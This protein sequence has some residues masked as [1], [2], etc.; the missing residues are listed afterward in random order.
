M[1]KRILEKEKVIIELIIVNYAPTIYN[2]D[3]HKPCT[4]KEEKNVNMV[5]TF[6]V[7][8]YAT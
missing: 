3:N 1:I 5:E 7:T 2:K 6:A 4:K 8:R